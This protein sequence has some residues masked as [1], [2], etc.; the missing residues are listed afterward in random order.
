MTW[1]DDIKEQRALIRDA[2]KRIEV[3]M[4]SV[5]LDD[6]RA[7]LKELGWEDTGRRVYGGYRVYSKDGRELLAP[8]YDRGEGNSFGKGVRELVAALMNDVG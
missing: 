5:S 3:A 7:V 6:L 4:D 2:E 8:N 1:L